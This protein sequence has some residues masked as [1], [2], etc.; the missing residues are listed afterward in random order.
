MAPTVQDK[1]AEL[2]NVWTVLQTLTVSFDR[3]GSYAAIRDE[4]RARD[5]LWAFIE[6]RL[7][8]RIATARGQLAAIL[9]EAD[10]EAHEL[11]E[12]LADDEDAMGYWRGL[13]DRDPDAV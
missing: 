11:L 13:T 5:A 7:F 2:L 9:E 6:P 10:A 3:I 12:H 1:F 4:F 8:E